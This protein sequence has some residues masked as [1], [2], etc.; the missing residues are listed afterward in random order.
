MITIGGHLMQVVEFKDTH[1]P[2]RVALRNQPG[3]GAA[4][5][6]RLAAAG[7]AGRYEQTSRP[8]VGGGWSAF[9]RGLVA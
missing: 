9:E 8:V 6:E 4:L 5:T 1:G 7:P 3:A 2:V